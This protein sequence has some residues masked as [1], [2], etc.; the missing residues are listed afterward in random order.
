MKQPLR[1][2]RL[3]QNNFLAELV[4]SRFVG[5]LLANQ[6]QIRTESLYP[7]AAPPNATTSL[8][9]LDH[10]VIEHPSL[11]LDCKGD[12]SPPIACSPA[13]RRSSCPTPRASQPQRPAAQQLLFSKRRRRAPRTPLGF[14]Q[15]SGF[16]TKPQAFSEWRLETSPAGLGRVLTA[17]TMRVPQRQRNTMGELGF[18][19]FIPGSAVNDNS[20]K[21]AYEFG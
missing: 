13:P 21:P 15:T 11:Q 16:A 1:T 14:G 9:N 19:L 4:I 6:T 7:V 2:A 20:S 18:V 5:C 10:L 17:N 8:A 12:N 3:L